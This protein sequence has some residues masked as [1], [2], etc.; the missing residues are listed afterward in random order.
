MSNGIVPYHNTII[1][2]QMVIFKTIRID[3]NVIDNF[4]CHRLGKLLFLSTIPIHSS[5]K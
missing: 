1:N 4:N 2:F 5:L 3:Q